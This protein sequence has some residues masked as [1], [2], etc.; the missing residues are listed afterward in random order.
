MQRYLQLNVRIDLNPPQEDSL[1]PARH[2]C[3]PITAPL[4]QACS[5][6]QGKPPSRRRSRASTTRCRDLSTS[7]SRKRGPITTGFGDEDGRRDR[8]SLQHR[9][10]REYGSP[11]S[12]GR[13]RRCRVIRLH[14]FSRHRDPCPTDGGIR[15]RA[16]RAR[17]RTDLAERITGGGPRVY[18]GCGEVVQCLTLRPPGRQYPRPYSVRRLPQSR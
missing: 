12:R 11:L 15:P 2:P 4:P 17:R 7:S 13:H 18:A 9:S 8:L 16:A 14:I 5:T 10:S 1:Q 6:S 3:R